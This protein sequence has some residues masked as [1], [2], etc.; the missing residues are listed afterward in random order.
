V[1]ILKC[2]HHEDV[3]AVLMQG[4]WPEAC[5]AELREHVAAC[6]DCGEMVLVTAAMRKARE[7][8][9]SRARLEP[10]GLIWWRAQLRK[11]QAA[12]ESVRRPIW[13]AQIFAIAMSLSVALGVVGWAAREGAGWRGWIAA[14]S[15]I[16]SSLN[17]LRESLSLLP[18]AASVAMLVFLGGVVVWLTVERE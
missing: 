8:S 15:R 6:R 2:S 5:S 13:G 16:G 17:S 10:A 4:H 7:V 11:R 14:M 3:R 9:A 1:N 18:L 12:M